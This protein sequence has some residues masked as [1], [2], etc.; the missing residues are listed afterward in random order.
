M[1]IAALALALLASVSRADICP[2]PLAG[3]CFA[4]DVATVGV[5]SSGSSAGQSVRCTLR[6]GIQG[7]GVLVLRAD[8]TYTSPAGTASGICPSGQVAIPA[9]KG[10][11][12]EK[13]GKLVLEPSNLDELGAALDACAGRELSIRRY[14]TTARI[15]EDG[16]VLLGVTKVRLVT[17][18]RVPVTT[19]VTERFRAFLVPAGPAFSSP[20]ARTLPACSIDLEPRCVTD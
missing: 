8:G 7:G 20:R 6:C 16:H 15:E 12:R 14:R 9:E 17:P 11:V 13:R 1:M 5:V 18:G 10:V 3:R 19:R 4:V 2:S